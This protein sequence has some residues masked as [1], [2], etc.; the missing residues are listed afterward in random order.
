MIRRL[1]K[2]FSWQQSKKCC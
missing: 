1:E 2:V